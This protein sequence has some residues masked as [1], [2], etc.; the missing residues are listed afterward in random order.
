VKGQS[1]LVEEVTDRLAV[2]FDLSFSRLREE[3]LSVMAL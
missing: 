2:N 3:Y 1:G